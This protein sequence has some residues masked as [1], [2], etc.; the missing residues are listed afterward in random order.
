M[1]IANAI[2]IILSEYGTKEVHKKEKIRFSSCNNNNIL[3]LKRAKGRKP[4]QNGWES[5]MLGQEGGGLGPCSPPSIEITRVLS[6]KNSKTP[7]AGTRV[8]LVVMAQIHF[9]P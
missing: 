5:G 7:L 2:V 3:R 4:R 9:H 8:F 6:E 1:Q